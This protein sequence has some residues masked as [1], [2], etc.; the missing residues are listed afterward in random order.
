ML[1]SEYIEKYTNGVPLSDEK[2]EFL[3]KEMLEDVQLKLKPFVE[4][5]DIS[6]YAREQ[7]SITGYIFLADT[8]NKKILTPSNHTGYF[9]VSEEG[10]IYDISRRKVVFGNYSSKGI[11]LK[12]LA[13][14]THENP[15]LSHYMGRAIYRNYVMWNFY[16]EE[17]KY[18]NP[19]GADFFKKKYENSL[20]VLAD[21]L[22]TKSPS[23]QMTS[24]ID[25]PSTSLESSG[26]YSTNTPLGG[27]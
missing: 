3:E 14:S 8:T 26:Y 23:F 27:V 7:D 2:L 11:K 1:S 21:F 19:S 13:Y 12:A 25:A 16:S 6:P 4:F 10:N 9:K 24:S 15:D 22:E 5:L 20:A 18:N 17:G